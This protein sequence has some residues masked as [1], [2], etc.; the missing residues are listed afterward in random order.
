MTSVI[1]NM[2]YMNSSLL[3]KSNVMEIDGSINM[4]FFQDVRYTIDYLLT[5]PTPVSI[6]IHFQ[7]SSPP[8]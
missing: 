4:Q 2:F 1:V 7:S 8:S 5:C 6:H 3:D